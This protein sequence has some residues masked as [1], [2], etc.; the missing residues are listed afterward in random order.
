MASQAR[1]LTN[2]TVVLFGRVKLEE[3]H[4]ATYITVNLKSVQIIEIPLP[5][6]LSMVLGVLLQLTVIVIIFFFG[7][8]WL[9]KNH[10][11]T[12]HL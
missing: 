8:L 6:F 11:M 2:F 10:V 7:S 4:M 1:S 3:F 5:R 9:K 12:E